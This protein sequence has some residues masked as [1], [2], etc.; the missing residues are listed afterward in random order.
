M[1]PASLGLVLQ[2][3]Y[4][5]G[6]TLV[7][8]WASSATT[9]YQ[10][11]ITRTGGTIRVRAS[12]D[13]P[14]RPRAFLLF[15]RRPPRPP[16]LELTDPDGCLGRHGVANRPWPKFDLTL[17]TGRVV[18]AC[19]LGRC[20]DCAGGWHYVTY[21]V[22]AGVSAPRA[23]RIP[24][25]M[26]PPPPMPLRLLDRETWATPRRH[27][28]VPGPSLSSTTFWRGG[29]AHRTTRIGDAWC[30]PAGIR[31]PPGLYAP[32]EDVPSWLSE[33]SDSSSAASEEPD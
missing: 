15:R 7:E 27:Y 30:K 25:Y 22:R 20:D 10:G 31:G 23:Y 12:P 32:C 4:S 5:E 16:A 19:W 3:S 8:R 21:D 28:W 14:W 29:R 1:W 2:L 26:L 9:P 18:A 24:T 17:V 33:P 13:A 6:P 11:E